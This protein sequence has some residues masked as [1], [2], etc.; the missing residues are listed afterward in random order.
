MIKELIEYL[1]C[2]KEGML[3][4]IIF[5]LTLDQRRRTTAVLVFRSV[6]N[7]NTQRNYLVLEC[8]LLF[9][10]KRIPAEF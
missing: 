10:R 8:P 9:R 3:Q 1:G 5:L 7:T 6:I 2:F 4:F